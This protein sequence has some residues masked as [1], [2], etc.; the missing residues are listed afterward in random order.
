[1]KVIIIEDELSAQKRLAQL[2]ETHF[3]NL[4]VAGIADCV[5]D[6]VQLI[7]DH[8]P[9]LVFMD[10]E[11]KDGS[12][13]QVMEQI[14][15]P[16]FSLIIT[17]AHTHYA[18]KAFRYAALDF[19]VKP[20]LLDE[21]LEAVQRAKTTP[22]RFLKER[23]DTLKNHVQGNKTKIAVPDTNGL[24]FL[25]IA[26]II[27][28][29]SDKSYTTLHLTDGRQIV[30]CHPLIDFEKLLLDFSFFR[31]HQSHLINLNQIK[32]FHRTDGG[33]LTMEDK[34]EVPVSRRRKQELQD[35][36]AGI[37]LRV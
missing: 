16:T 8:A 15:A 10:V 34:K 4:E 19:L 6:A 25:S 36:I 17:T 37:A 5:A 23:L 31:V 26:D 1:M 28:I 27:R 14:P 20:I 22:P 24:V 2:L 30:N 18:T 11:L 29:E 3:P 35:K 33:L 13:F 9:D 12:G 21:F 7:T 32:N